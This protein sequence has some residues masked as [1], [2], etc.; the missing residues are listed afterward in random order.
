MTPESMPTDVLASEAPT[1]EVTIDQVET[2]SKPPRGLPWHARFGLSWSTGTVPVVLMLLLGAALG[3]AGLALLTPGVLA[4]IDPVLPVAV[5][6]LGILAGL[7]FTRPAAPDRWSLLGKANF[8][9]MLT[10]ILVAGGIWLVM[11]VSPDF[12]TADVLIVAVMAGMCASMSAAL[13][14]TDPDRLRPAVM[15]MR[16]LDAVL[17]ALV[18]A[19]VLASLHAPSP[20][21]S[22]GL[23]IQAAILAL[24]ISASAWLLL[25]ETSTLT[26]QRV[27]SIAALLLVG[28]IADYL[29]LSALV[30]GLLAGLFWGHIGGVARDCIERE[31]TYL[32]HPLVVLMLLAAGA[33][34]TISGWI[35]VLAAAYLLLR[36]AG[37]LLGSWLVRRLPGVVISRAAGPALLSPGV[38]GIAFALDAASMMDASAASILAATVLGSIGSQLLAGLWQ[39]TEAPE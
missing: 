11:P 14:D 6:A 1:G 22:L 21:A 33:R 16:D 31:V 27:F 28:G 12:E 9:S 37:K 4:V 39:P 3:P 34:T 18:G 36:V 25:S 29:S 8:Q 13:P 32:R 15:R 20:L 5:A 24:L 17:P 10:G 35:L 7:E 38:F 19:L 30:S 26:E 23:T 2:L